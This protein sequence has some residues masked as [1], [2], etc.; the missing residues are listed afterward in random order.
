LKFKLP[1][2]RSIVQTAHKNGAAS[3]RFSLTPGEVKRIRKAER[4][5]GKQAGLV[6]VLEILRER[7]KNPES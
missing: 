1:T 3:I 7:S 6:A 5:G 4:K 2:L